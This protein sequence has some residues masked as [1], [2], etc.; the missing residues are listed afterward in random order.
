M[1]SVGRDVSSN[2]ALE[3]S[4]GMFEV[5]LQS[6]DDERMPEQEGIVR[7]P[8]GR[9]LPAEAGGNRTRIAF[10]IDVEPGGSV[11]IWLVKMV[12]LNLLCR[13]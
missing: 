8:I 9:Q 13:R 1:A 6:V 12:S 7:M 10:E 3:A 2:E 5:R 4:D 11:P